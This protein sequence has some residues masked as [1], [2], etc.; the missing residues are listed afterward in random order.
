MTIHA[1]EC[2]WEQTTPADCQYRQTHYYCPHPEHAC[3]CLPK[4]KL[5]G[6]YTGTIRKADGTVVPNDEW[7]VFRAKDLAVP[8]V[9]LAYYDECAR[10]GSPESHLKGVMDLY[11]RVDRWQMGHP[12]Q[13]KVPD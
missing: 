9:L 13:C 11:E 7:I 10:R 3:T 5:D 12:D 2:A 6:K 8:A 1:P 4:V